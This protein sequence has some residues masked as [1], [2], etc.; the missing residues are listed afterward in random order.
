MPLVFA[1]LA[2]LVLCACEPVVPVAPVDTRSFEGFT[3]HSSIPEDPV[4]IVYLFHGTHGSADFAL[5]IETLD[6]TNELVERGYGWVATESTERTGNRRWQVFDPSIATNPD[7]AR[8][9]RLHAD[10]IDTTGVDSATPIFGIG[11]SNGA[12]MVTL[13]GQAFTLAGYP[14]AAVAPFNG[15]AAPSV[16]AAGG[17]SVP[18]F[19][20]TSINDSGSLAQVIADQQDSATLGVPT[21]LMIRAE[22][23]LLPIRFTRVPAVDAS[24]AAAVYAALLGTGAWGSDGTRVLDLEVTVELLAGL[25]LPTATGATPAQLRNQVAAILAVH[26][27]VGFYRV[28][29]AD[30]FDA[31]R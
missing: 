15:R 17:L 26:Q 28:A 24:E 14:V 1:L 2:T 16:R 6:Q 27:F 5:K 3:V 29:L 30:F 4:G 25:Q 20:V 19:W 21:R 18:G 12:R 11:M 23:P 10:L 13:F 31:H 7:L 9:S 8:L 22:E